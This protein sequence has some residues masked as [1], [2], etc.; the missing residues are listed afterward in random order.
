MS[1]RHHKQTASCWPRGRGKTCPVRNSMEVPFLIERHCGSW[2]EPRLRQLHV[3]LAEA[4]QSSTGFRPPA[5][6]QCAAS[7]TAGVR[8]LVQLALTHFELTHFELTHFELTHWQSLLRD[9]TCLPALATAS[10][11]ALH[12]HPDLQ[13]V[14]S[15][16][17][18]GS[19]HHRPVFASQLKR[20]QRLGDSEP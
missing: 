5:S 2:R 17:S 13:I 7:A 6:S 4:R 11:I 12:E 1:P 19:F 18:T 20:S 14:S 10:A 16:P 9:L 8:V 15:H 3:V